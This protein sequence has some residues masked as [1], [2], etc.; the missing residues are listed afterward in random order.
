M[1]ARFVNTMSG[2]VHCPLVCCSEASMAKYS[3]VLEHKTPGPRYRPPLRP[4]GAQN[5]LTRPWRGCRIRRTPN[6]PLVAISEPFFLDYVR[7]DRVPLSHGQQSPAPGLSAIPVRRGGRPGCSECPNGANSV[8]GAKAGSGEC[9]LCT[10]IPKR[11]PS[12][13][14]AMQRRFRSSS[15]SDIRRHSTVEGYVS[16]Q[17]RPRGTETVR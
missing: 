2:G 4:R 8:H 10:L 3:T 9:S 15:T 13:L 6:A 17:T 7:L 14:R 1:L 5:T 16:P 11:Q 12:W